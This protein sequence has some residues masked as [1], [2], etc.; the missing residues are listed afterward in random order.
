MEEW[1]D[2][3]RNAKSN[4]NEDNTMFGNILRSPQQDPC[5]DQA[6]WMD[7]LQILVHQHAKTIVT[8]QDLTVEVEKLKD[9][10]SSFIN[11]ITADLSKPAGPSHLHHHNLKQDVW[12]SSPHKLIDSGF[13]TETKESNNQ[14]EEDDPLYSLLDLIQT[15]VSNSTCSCKSVNNG[16][17]A[18]A[19]KLGKLD[20]TLGFKKGLENVVLDRN[21]IRA[22]LREVDTVELQR[23]V[24]FALAKVKTLEAHLNSLSLE[25]NSS[26]RL[27]SQYLALSQEN[28]QLRFKLKEQE[29]QLE[30]TKAKLRILE[31]NNIVKKFEATTPQLLHSICSPPGGAIS[32]TPTTPTFSQNKN[33]SQHSQ[34]TLILH[35]NSVNP[36]NTNC[37]NSYN[38]INRKCPDP[39]SP[40]VL[41][42]NANGTSNGVVRSEDKCV[43]ARFESDEELIELRK[44]T[45]V[46]KNSRLINTTNNIYSST[47]T[48]SGSK[49]RPPS[50][51]PTRPQTPRKPCSPIQPMSKSPISSISSKS[52]IPIAVTRLKRNN[53]NNNNKKQGS[54]FWSQWF[55]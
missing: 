47:P 53:N 21:V 33:V 18:S 48:L 6:G 36:S 37:S 24:L 20:E 31:K 27:A 50:K 10:R 23:Q 11:S 19:S 26:S 9:F 29:I 28:E 22:I 17:R 38:I 54:N 32:P 42:A 4:D 7:F 5:D 34:E 16:T 13:S 55:A 39:P 12:T 41:N 43:S 1:A 15:K 45:R 3:I 49:P 35:T 30:G 52:S 44:S 40:L 46:D 14:K 51:I 8:L 25:E 2:V